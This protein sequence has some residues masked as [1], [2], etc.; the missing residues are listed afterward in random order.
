MPIFDGFHDEMANDAE[1]RR[2]RRGNQE[3]ARRIAQS[4][5]LLHVMSHR[6]T[7]LGLLTG[8]Q[9]RI[10]TSA[11]G[12]YTSVETQK[13]EKDYGFLPAVY[14]YPGRA[15]KEHGP[16]VFALCGKEELNYSGAATYIGLYD[17]EELARI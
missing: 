14:C 11:T 2:Q 13:R 15:Y 1:R 6:I 3:E 16:A 9:R 8:E 17:R 4:V 12:G 5:P 7:L 10:P